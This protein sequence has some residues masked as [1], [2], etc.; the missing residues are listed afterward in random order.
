MTVTTSTT[1]PLP[2]LEEYIAG[3]DAAAIMGVSMPTFKRYYLNGRNGVRLRTVLLGGKRK[4]TREWI[5]RFILEVSAAD[6]TCYLPDSAGDQGSD[7]SIEAAYE[8]L[9]S[10]GVLQSTE[11]QE[12]QR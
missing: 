9:R 6:S 12:E 8:Y 5:D 3:R 2:R 11:T 7:E 1:P 4:T 10:V